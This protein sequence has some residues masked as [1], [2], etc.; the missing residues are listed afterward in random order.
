MPVRNKS[1]FYDGFGGSS[2][3]DVF[4]SPKPAKVSLKRPKSSS[5]VSSNK[6]KKLAPIT[7]K[8]SES[9]PKT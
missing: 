2:K 3:D 7:P 6:L 5:T 9:F 8:V 4:P 1:E